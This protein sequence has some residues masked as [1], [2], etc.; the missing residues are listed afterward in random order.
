M[1]CYKVFSEVVLQLWI[2]SF[3]GRVRLSDLNMKVKHTHTHTHSEESGS[4]TCRRATIELLTANRSVAR[5][6]ANQQ[7]GSSIGS[8]ISS[9]F[10]IT[11]EKMSRI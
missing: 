4:P 5:P 9:F 11:A 8:L 2:R 6:L 1:K 3:R 10:L 7:H